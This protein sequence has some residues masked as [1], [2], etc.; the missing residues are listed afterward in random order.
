MIRTGI[1]V[2]PHDLVDEGAQTVIDR[3]GALLPGVDPIVGVN[4]LFERHPYPTGVLPH[5]PRHRVIQT[6]G[7]LALASS[8]YGRLRVRQRVEDLTPV[9]VDAFTAARRAGMRPIAWFSCLNG[10]YTDASRIATVETLD[11]SKVPQ[12]LC[13]ARPESLRHALELCRLVIDSLDADEI[14]V[15][16]IRYPDWSG[17]SVV[18]ERLLSCFCPACRQRLTAAGLDVERLGGQLT[19]MWRAAGPGAVRGWPEDDAARRW[20]KVRA[21]TITDFVQSLRESLWKEF[22]HVRLYLNL[23]PPSQAYLLGQDFRAL[24]AHCDGAKF[25][26]YHR[27]G[28]G[29]ALGH[30]VDTVPP[31]QRERVFQDLLKAWNLPYRISYAEFLRCGLPEDFVA[32]ETRQA[33]ALMAPR[34]VFSGIQLWDLPAESVRSAIQAAL[35]PGPRGLFLYCYGWTPLPVLQETGAWM[36]QELPKYVA[37]S[38]GQQGN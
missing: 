5:N 16:R 7:R 13:P 34:P 24:R 35:R 25:F 18:A 30:L 36:D 14:L 20:L 12:W 22:P 27:L 8:R 6:R 1:H 29:A 21:D 17:Q 38:R 26:P 2:H 19:S 4:T 32:D 28:G 10:A 3:I 9:I 31:P 23:W 37:R 33:V 11:G 15:D